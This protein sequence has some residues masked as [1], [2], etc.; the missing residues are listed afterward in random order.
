MK[1]TEE[2]LKEELT[3]LN[4]SRTESKPLRQEEVTPK[5]SSLSPGCAHREFAA[6]NQDILRN[7]TIQGRNHGFDCNSVGSESARE[8]ENREN[9]IPRENLE[10]WHIENI[11]CAADTAKRDTWSRLSLP[12]RCGAWDISKPTPRF[13]ITNSHGS[14]VLLTT[15]LTTPRIPSHGSDV[16]LTTMLTT[17]RIYPNKNL[18]RPITPNPLSRPITPNPLSRSIT[19]SP[20]S[21]PHPSLRF[22]SLVEIPQRKCALTAGD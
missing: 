11:P 20:L 5:A 19:P 12:P 1:R 4:T 14:D 22:K 6:E 17:P 21:R 16:L 7:A 3:R 15:T 18:S 9:I 13:S 2:K 10:R 8:S